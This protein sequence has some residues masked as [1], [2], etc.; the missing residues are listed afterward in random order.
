[1]SDTGTAELI[2]ELKK[3]KNAKCV[4]CGYCCRK[5]PCGVS[6]RV[7]GPVTECPA[8]A[9]NREEKRYY[10][11][12]CL[13]PDPIGARYREELYIGEGCCSPL[14]NT[15]RENIPP[16]VPEEFDKIQIDKQFRSFLHQIGNFGMSGDLLWLLVDGTARELGFGKEWKREVFRVIR[17]ERSSITDEFMGEVPDIV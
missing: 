15:D 12:L 17:E 2:H 11:A 1:M 3:A 16:P 5:A 6:L 7:F 10:C 4:G 13:K 14:F 8:L 9:Y